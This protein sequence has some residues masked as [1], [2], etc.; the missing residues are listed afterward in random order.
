[1]PHETDTPTKRNNDQVANVG[2]PDDKARALRLLRHVAKRPEGLASLVEAGFL[3]SCVAALR[4]EAPASAGCRQQ[5]VGAL[6]A[7]TGPGGSALHTRG[8]MLYSGVVPG[9]VALLDKSGA[10]PGG[11]S[12]SLGVQDRAAKLL[13]RLADVDAR[14]FWQQ[15]APASEAEADGDGRARGGLDM[16]VDLLSSGSARCQQYTLALL[17]RL[18]A[19]EAYRVQLIKVRSRREQQLVP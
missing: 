5:A 3:D 16:L 6:L 8:R 17:L 7:L 19:R 11:G 14:D 9:V 13:S 2:A 12:L 18:A 1:M 15:L 10:A 4:D